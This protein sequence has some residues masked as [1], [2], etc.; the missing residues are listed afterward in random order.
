MIVIS[1]KKARLRGLK[2]YFTGKPCKQG[3]LETRRVINSSCLICERDSSREYARAHAE[4]QR[5]RSKTY[6]HAYPEESKRKHRIWVE[7]N[8]ERNRANNRRWEINNPD[9]KKELNRKWKRENLSLVKADNAKSRAAKLRTTPPWA[10]WNALKHIYIN[11]PNGY[12]VD[13]IVPLRGKGVCGLH[14]PWNLQ[15]LTP[16]QNNHKGN[17]L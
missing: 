3:H 4:Q 15:Y 5:E 12:H 14:V 1:C 2:F 8:R 16:E 6:Y 10:D 17:K 11:C 9:Q 7:K 13:H